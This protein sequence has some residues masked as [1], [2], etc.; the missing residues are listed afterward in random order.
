M[1]EELVQVPQPLEELTA[2]TKSQ[3]NI[4]YI[5]GVLFPTQT[6][7]FS[8]RQWGV[9]QA[10]DAGKIPTDSSPMVVTSQPPGSFAKDD[11][12]WRL[13]FG[14]S[15][16]AWLTLFNSQF[17]SNSQPTLA[18]DVYGD[19]VG[20]A[21]DFNLY[22][23]ANEVQQIAYIANKDTVEEFRNS[24]RLAD[25]FAA[26]G[27]GIRM[28][29]MVAGYGKTVAMRPTDPDPQDPRKNDESHKL[30]RETWKH[31][32]LV[33]R[34]DERTGCWSV[35]NDLITGQ[36]K[37]DLGTLMFSTNPDETLGFPFL[38]GKITDAFWVRKTEAQHGVTGKESDFEKSGEALTH[39]E[40]RWYDDITKTVAALSSIFTI[41]GPDAADCHGAATGP[42]VVGDEE[43]YT[44]TL[45]DLKHS[46]HFN[47]A[48]TDK[49]GQL[50]FTT[51]DIPPDE[52]CS[53]SDGKYHLGTLYF[54]DEGC[55][56]DIAV[57]IDECELAGGHF[58]KMAA[59]DIL[60][61]ERMTHICNFISS[62]GGGL[63]AV[64]IHQPAGYSLPD[65]QD[66]N[67][68]AVA[69]SLIC[70]HDNLQIANL[71]AVQNAE[72]LANA[73]FLGATNYTSFAIDSLVAAINAWI[74]GSLI[75]ALVACCGEG[76]SSV[77]IIAPEIPSPAP[78]GEVTRVVPEYFNC[79][80]S[81]LPA[82]RLNCEYCWGV[83]LN[84]PCGE[85]PAVFA[86]DACF[87][88]DP[89]VATTSYGNC[90]TH[91]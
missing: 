55:V 4:D 57:K 15:H 45:L 63:G 39:L 42:E 60:I 26:R 5:Q 86:G 35:F 17:M 40:H 71:N 28:P 80:L 41:P 22:K 91:S 59:N 23:L 32:P 30:A 74:T 87:V 37:E 19:G 82:P 27:L 61:A 83:H 66:L 47:M 85:T 12:G 90:Q 29:S 10:S 53:P 76:A 69:A 6:Y 54:N 13:T 14:A 84:V 36:S 58:E 77:G 56:W 51:E 65:T 20:T 62:W 31:G 25:E 8:G 75:P 52:I 18:E 68:G 70:T 7:A 33:G 1:E 64:S 2:L 48:G 50:N 43:T 67:F 46:V 78:V 24:P 73:A 9:A 38:K 79:D 88:N 34:W 89:P 49:D 11:L 16:D 44:G 72:Q 81:V 3:G 21:R